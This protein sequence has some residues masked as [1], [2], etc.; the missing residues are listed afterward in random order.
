MLGVSV[1][2]LC[3]CLFACVCAHY[4]WCVSL[5]HSVCVICECLHACVCACDFVS[6]DYVCAC[7]CAC[8]RVCV[9]DRERECVCVYTF[10]C[11]CTQGHL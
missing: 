3:E 5:Y 10:V 9:C 6:N 4:A 8:M 11:Q 2:V 1:C 7:V